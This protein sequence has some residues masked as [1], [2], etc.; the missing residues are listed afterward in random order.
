MKKLNEKRDR[1]FVLAFGIGAIAVRDFVA[2][3]SLTARRVVQLVTD[4]GGARNT[5]EGS[6]TVRV[7]NRVGLVIT[8]VTGL[9]LNPHNVTSRVNNHILIRWRTTNPYPHEV[10]PTPFLRTRHHIRPESS[11][12]NTFLFCIFV[13]VTTEAVKEERNPFYVSF[14]SC[15]ETGSVIVEG[16]G[17]VEY[18]VSVD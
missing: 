5:G 4:G 3:P 15:V 12:L 10:L 7:K 13:V 1:R 2:T 9:A 17:A 6:G 11:I 14:D 8:L 16:G 18:L